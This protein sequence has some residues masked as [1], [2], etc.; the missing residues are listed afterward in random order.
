VI[1]QGL[2]EPHCGAGS[3]VMPCALGN[4]AVGSFRAIPMSPPRLVR[5]STSTTVFGK[6]FRWAL[7]TL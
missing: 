4:I 5:S 3:V 2:V 1:A 7:T 6:A